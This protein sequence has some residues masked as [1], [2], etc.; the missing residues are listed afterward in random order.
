MVLLENNL[1]MSLCGKGK[2]RKGEQGMVARQVVK[3]NQVFDHNENLIK[4]LGFGFEG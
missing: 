1:D 3:K 2:I 4:N